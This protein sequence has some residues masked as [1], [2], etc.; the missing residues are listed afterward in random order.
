MST[1][2]CLCCW[3]LPEAL[4]TTSIA[5]P[6]N[7]SILIY[8]SNEV[9]DQKEKKI[10]P[11]ILLENITNEYR[12]NTIIE[13]LNYNGIP[14]NVGRFIHVVQGR[15][16]Y[17]VVSS[18]E[19]LTTVGG[20]KLKVITKNNKVN[21]KLFGAIGGGL[22]D[23]YATIQATINYVSSLPK[24]GIVYFPSGKYKSSQDLVVA[25]N[26]TILQGEGN[27]GTTI[28]YY[29][30]G[31]GISF[32]TTVKPVFYVGLKDI[33]IED[34]SGLGTHGLYLGYARESIFENV[35]I[36]KGFSQAG[37]YLDGDS[38]AGCWSNR[39]TN[40]WSL[41]VAG[42]GF[43]VVDQSNANIF[44]GCRTT[45]TGLDG[46]MLHRAN[47]VKIH[48]CQFE[49]SQSGYE[50]HIA[51][52]DTLSA[53]VLGLD[54]VGCYFEL[55]PS[56]GSRALKV[57][58]LG[59]T[60]SQVEGLNMSGCT[61]WGA[62]AADYAVELD[63][64]IGL[65]NVFGTITG[66]YAHGVNI[67]EVRAVTSGD[68]V[69]CIGSISRSDFGAGTA[70]PLLD[71]NS[72]SGGSSS[73]V[74]SAKGIA[75]DTQLRLAQYTGSPSSPIGDGSMWWSSGSA[76]PMVMKGGISTR[77]QVVDQGT[78]ATRPPSKAIGQMFFDSTIGKPIWWNGTTWID[79]TG[80][81]V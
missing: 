36:K 71:N 26:N 39:F 64:T 43:E 72:G 15:C 2:S 69:I 40:V 66:N 22:V 49:Q 45:L 80:I 11:I 68:R 32:G 56:T 17:E 53:R 41:E 23:D 21:V 62:D 4:S 74:V 46:F 3:S 52:K 73:I 47:G 31:K 54:I 48:A 60:K 12:F 18:G 6:I 76:L 34:M 1:N 30:S 79:S 55:K 67:A 81:E 78:T 42:N 51:P 63:S 44:I 75:L 24:G 50:I 35:I 65:G 8:D 13:L 38:S 37:V 16:Q 70:L 5:D 19:H 61:V 14:L 9:S 28:E 20:D 59:V 33:G 77:M 29:G 10:S 27:R 7:D 58:G 57:E 25:N